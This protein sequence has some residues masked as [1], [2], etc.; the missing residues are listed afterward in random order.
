MSAKRILSFLGFA[1]F[2]R[3]FVKG[4]SEITAPLTK[5]TRKDIV[6]TWESKKQK[7]FNMLKK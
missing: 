4:Y 1:G 6:F 2:Y 7:A 5:M 3:K